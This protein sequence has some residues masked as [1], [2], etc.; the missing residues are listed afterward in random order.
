MNA[1]NIMWRLAQLSSL[2]FQERYVI[3]G[4][5]DEYV[6]DTELLENIDWLKYLV[7]RPGERAQLTNVQLA[8]LEDLFD[9]IDAH[10]AEALSGKSRQDAAALIRGSEVWNEMRAKAASA[11]EAFG[12]SAD[13]TVDE[14]DRMS[15]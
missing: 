2:P 15:E 1:E 10:S 11:L 5:A 12:V 3:G 6:I 4:R 7:R 9:Y 14:I 13:L 8:T